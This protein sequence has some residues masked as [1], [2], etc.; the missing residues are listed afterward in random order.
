MP[1]PSFSITEI[2]EEGVGLTCEVHPD[3]LMLSSEEG[4]VRNCLLLEATIIPSG[5][6]I[7]VSGVLTGMFVRQCVRCLNE[8]DDAVELP[9]IAEFRHASGPARRCMKPARIESSPAMKR[10][11][12]EDEELACL[13]E[14]PYLCV[15]DRLEL[16]EMLRE[17]IILSTPMQPL[18]HEQ[19]LGLCP[20]CGQNLNSGTC[21]CLL[22]T[23][24]NPFA[25]LQELR[26]KGRGA[27][28]YGAP[29]DGVSKRSEE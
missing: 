13:E 2:P 7:Q 8:Y 12:R 25:I 22:E 16:T 6:R 29:R 5:D 21:G 3:E 19:C 10:G 9:F 11:A 23:H 15:G 28:Q 24:K 1:L 20:A 4:Y 14:E 18:C 26:I 17:Q 27:S